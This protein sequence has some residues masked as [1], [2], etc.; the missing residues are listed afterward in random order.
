MNGW[1]K[2]LAV[3]LAVLGVVTAGYAGEVKRMGASAGV[4][5]DSKADSTIETHTGT[6]KVQFDG[7]GKIVSGI[8]L[9]GDGGDQVINTM[10]SIRLQQ[11]DGDKVTVTGEKDA[12][13]KLV[14][15]K[16]ERFVEKKE[17]TN[18]NIN[19]RRQT[20]NNRRALEIMRRMLRK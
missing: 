6:I 19:N 10:R 1:I 4:G 17:V 8:T 20:Q 2:S 12:D 9:S 14:V 5:T 16:C 15:K 7:M 11:Y 3:A 18:R 13:G